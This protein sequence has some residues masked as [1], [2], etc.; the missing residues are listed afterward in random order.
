MLSS[1][2]LSYVDESG[3]AGYAGS[4][5]YTVCCVM[6]DAGSWPSA[7]DGFISFRRFLSNQFSIRVR[8][9]IKA[10]HLVRGK[11]VAAGLG[12]QQRRAVF[13]Q[14]M[15][16]ADKLG[17]MVFAVV[18][19]KAKIKKQTMNPRDLAWEFL[20]QRLERASTKSGEPV[21]LL[22]DEGDSLAIRKLARKARRAGQAGSAFGTGTLKMPFKLL[23]DDPVPR[24]SQQSYFV[25]LA[26]LAAYAAYRRV[27]PP[28]NKA[29]SVCPQGMW[30]ELHGAR[31]APANM[32]KGGAS[33]GIVIWP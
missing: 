9:E 28:P 32:V 4:Q 10:N 12:D 3:D 31:Y 33:A 15:R 30:D 17:L 7:F 20:L 25:Q 24:N 16:L 27:H 21:M 19:E 6:M 5:T 18:I 2:L 13:R 29:G 22:H 14:H 1:M 8:D 11:G 26:D 23:L